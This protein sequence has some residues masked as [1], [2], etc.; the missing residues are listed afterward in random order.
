MPSVRPSVCLFVCRPSACRPT[1]LAYLCV[2]SGVQYEDQVYV[3]ADVRHVRPS[4]CLSV[5]RPS[6]CRPT[7]L[8]YL[9]VDSGVQYEDQVYVYAVRPSVCLFC[10]P[11]VRLSSYLSG[12]PVC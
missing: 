11:S 7:C 9:C 10:V 3:Y 6:A 12:V 8:A 4:V 5:C 2:D 1:C